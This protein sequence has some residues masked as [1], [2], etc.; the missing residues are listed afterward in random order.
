M[1]GEFFESLLCA[2]EKKYQ[3]ILVTFLY[4]LDKKDLNKIVFNF[5]FLKEENKSG[6]REISKKKK[7]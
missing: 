2:I 6:I 1:G 3:Q 5:H 4:S 7:E